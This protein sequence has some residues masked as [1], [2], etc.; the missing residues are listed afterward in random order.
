MFEAHL[1]AIP[2]D[3]LIEADAELERAIAADMTRELIVEAPLRPADP[4]A[5]WATANPDQALL[6]LYVS[7]RP[8]A[9]LDELM[10]L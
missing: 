6:F 9:A 5:G 4:P 2:A 1:A 3:A 10:A 7:P 8:C